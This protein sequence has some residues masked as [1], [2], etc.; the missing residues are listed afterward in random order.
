MVT[1]EKIIVS[2]R[3]LYSTEEPEAIDNLS[4]RL[5]VRQG[6]TEV[7]TH[8]WTSINIANN[9]NYFI[10]DTGDMI[11]NEYFL[12]IKAISNQETNV[13]SETIKFQVVNQANYFGNP[14][15]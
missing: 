12:D 11:P 7:E 5:Y 8:S 2:A 10:L 13:Y 6:T 4:Y 3:K 9:Q 15:A 14:P 1:L